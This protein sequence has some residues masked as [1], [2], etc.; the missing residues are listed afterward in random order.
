MT[1]SWTS[2]AVGWLKSQPRWRL[3]FSVIV[4]VV[5]VASLVHQQRQGYDV[6]PAL[7]AIGGYAIFL[8]AIA[9]LVWIANH[10]QRGIEHALVRAG[11]MGGFK[12]YVSATE[13]TVA[14]VIKA[15]LWIVGATVLAVV[16]FVVL[17]RIGSGIRSMSP[18]A[19]IIFGA[20]I[21]AY[22]IVSTRPR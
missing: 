5:L 17:D 16:A 20:F 15:A 3:W 2:A 1:S 14:W 7:F 13:K 10:L 6:M 11:W 9:V 22:A 18:S 19:A 21:I 8:A 4:V 12:R